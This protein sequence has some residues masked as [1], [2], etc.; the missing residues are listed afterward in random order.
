MCRRIFLLDW[1]INRK[2]NDNDSTDGEDS[3]TIDK[4]EQTS[5]GVRH[6]TNDKHHIFLGKDYSNY[7]KNDFQSVEKFDEG[8]KY[9]VAF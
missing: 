8:W 3:E 5:A 4:N 1:Q 7:Y 2:N 9:F 6:M